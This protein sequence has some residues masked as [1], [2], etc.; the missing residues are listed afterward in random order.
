ML[1]GRI[2]RGSNEYAIGARA[3]D[4]MVKLMVPTPDDRGVRRAVI[5]HCDILL[6]H[7]NLRNV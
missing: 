5:L 3:A 2:T 4:M 7:L 1:C 6:L